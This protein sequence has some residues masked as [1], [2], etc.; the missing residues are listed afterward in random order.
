MSLLRPFDSPVGRAAMET[1]SR[2][3]LLVIAV[4][5]GAGTILAAVGLLTSSGYLISR[6]AEQ[7]EILSL[8]VVIVAVRFFGISRAILRYFERLVSH[9]LAF[10]TLTDLR[11]RFFAKL[12]PLVPGGLGDAKRGDLL[13]TFVG[14]VDQM[15]NLYL[16][17][18]APPL[19]AVVSS[20]VCVLVAS[21]MLPLAGLVLAGMLLLAGIG[22]PLA[23]RAAARRAGRRQATARAALSTDLLEIAAGSAELAVA[24]RERDWLRRA[25]VSDERVVEL[26]RSDA[27]SGG[28]AVGLST[29]LAVMTI[30]AVTAVTIPAVHSGDLNGVLLAALALLALASFEPILPLGQA[31]AGIDA[32]ADAAGRIEAVT[33]RSAPVTEP[34]SPRP[35]P[36]GGAIRFEDVSFA[37]A[38]DL[39]PVLDGVDFSFGPGDAVALVGP[40]GTGK[41]TLSELMVR[42]R[43]PGSG[44]VTIGDTDVRDLDGT[45]LRRRVRLAPQDAYLFD[46]SIRE[47]VALGRADA[48]PAEIEVALAKVG[49]AEWLAELPEG[50]DTAVGEGGARVSGGQRQRIAMARTVI[51]GADFLVFDE[52]TTHLD[53]DGAKELEHL[54]T[55][56]RETGSGILMITHEIIDPERFDHVFELRHGKIGEIEPVQFI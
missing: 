2:W 40:S 6:A 44:R 31:A 37:Y 38:A 28:L 3:R 29:L 17:G 39:E 49:L 13:S 48:T 50:I 34:D 8:T 45:E 53:P 27:V 14:D 22:M 1:R 33:E 16:R 5:L 19:I 43:D 7:P 30:I 52:P 10:R 55:G 25:A 42:F 41:S 51:S 24:G 9:D 56:L 36:A 23:T 26:Q 20:L 18:L 46:G 54:L 21:L 35:F 32:C 4:L 47:N 12:V 11:T 15:Q